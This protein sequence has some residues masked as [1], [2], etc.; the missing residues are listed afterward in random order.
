MVQ[1]IVSPVRASLSQCAQRGAHPLT[2]AEAR[3]ST[4]NFAKLPELL[5]K[6][7]AHCRSGATLFLSNK[8][9]QNPK[10]GIEAILCSGGGAF[11][12]YLLCHR[13]LPALL[14]TKF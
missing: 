7:A 1:L 14:L 3:R 9:H 10:V 8:V 11:G 6:V 5:R 2:H 13:L 12:Q 4:S